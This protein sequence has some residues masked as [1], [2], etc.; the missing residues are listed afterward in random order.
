[1]DVLYVS[2]LDGTL[3]NDNQT[4]NV[5]TIE[6]LNHLIEHGMHFTIATARSIESTKEIIK[7]LNV[8][9]PIV[10]MNGVFIYDSHNER[11]IKTNY[12]SNQLGTQIIQTYL[13]SGLNPIVYTIDHDGNSRIYYKGTFNNSEAN[14]IGNR[15]S[16]GD[17][18]FKLVNN[19]DECMNEHIITINA[20]DTFNKLEYAYKQFMNEPECNCHFGPDIYS[21]G[22]H[23]LEIADQRATKKEAVLFLKSKYNFKKLVCFGDNLNDLSMFEAADEKYAVSNAHEIL[24]NKADKIIDSNN[25]NGVSTFLSSIYDRSSI[26]PNEI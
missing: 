21:P 5:E 18:R 17:T 20:I 6:T 12:L 15:L 24:R 1:M 3:L 22:Y 7:E 16:K 14:Y 4:L 2:D 9:L 11:Y 13:Q 25:S 26:G 10:L 19:Y 8:N 23:W